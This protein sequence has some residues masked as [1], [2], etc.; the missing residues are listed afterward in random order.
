MLHTKFRE[1]KPA[2]SGEEDIRKFLTIYGRGSHLGQVTRVSPSNFRSPYPWMLHI[3][4]NF[5]W[6]SL[7]RD[8]DI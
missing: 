5:D 6:P 2:C 8:E 1:N 3:K 7:F 4:F